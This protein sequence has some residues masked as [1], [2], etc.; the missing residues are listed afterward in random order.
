MLWISQE[1]NP[2]SQERNILKEIEN[3]LEPQHF[4]HVSS[5][6]S[7]HPMEALW[8]GLPLPPALRFSSAILDRTL[9]TKA[10]GKGS[11]LAMDL[12]AASHVCRTRKE[13]LSRSEQDLEG[14]Q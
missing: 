1:D 5:V 2:Q 14:H 8:G 12:K 9:R 7:S 11:M 13:S 10:R 3:V 6:L 4:S